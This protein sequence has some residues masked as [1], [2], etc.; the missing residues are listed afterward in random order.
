MVY[1]IFLMSFCLLGGL[2]AVASN[3]SPYYGAAGLVVSAAVGCGVLVWFGNSFV[4][5][6]LFLIYLGGMLVVF[7]YSVALAAD[8]Y[9]ETWGNW[10]VGL[11]FVGYVLLVVVLGAVFGGGALDVGIGVE[12]VDSVGLF[13]VRADFSGVS[14]LYSWGG[15]CLLVSGWG[16]LLALF[17]ALELSRGLVRGGLRV[18]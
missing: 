11:Y 12:G 1:L 17:V 7:A 6:V 5:L 9:P 15:F 16:L 2:V 13:S 3:P 18:V 10:S 14:L 4:S 8:P